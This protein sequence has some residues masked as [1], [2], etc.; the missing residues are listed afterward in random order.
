MNRYFVRPPREAFAGLGDG[1]IG[2]QSS[3]AEY[4]YLGRG[5]LPWVKS[6]HFETA[7]LLARPQFGRSAIDYGCADGVLLPSLSPRFERILAVDNNEP[8]VRMSRTVADRL[9]LAN[10]EVRSNDGYDPSAF[11]AEVR[12]SGDFHVLFCL[13][14][15]EHVGEADR[16]WEAK[17]EFVDHLFDCL[18]P[19]GLVIISVPSMTGA[20][21]LVQRTMLAAL[22]LH[23]EPMTSREL[24][25][26]VV[27]KRTEAL[28]PRWEHWKHLGFNERTLERHLRERFR[29]TAKKS[30][31]FSQV[32]AVR[33]P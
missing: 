25:D 10:V 31:F 6:L 23:R 26:A 27:H 19:G 15:L 5:P 17:M 33:R 28:E 29:V 1:Y 22:K 2:E 24:W 30:L 32:F 21:L 14:T 7:L 16:L 20:A 4:N 3:Y 12:A 8:A 11:A 13:E 18:V 9:D